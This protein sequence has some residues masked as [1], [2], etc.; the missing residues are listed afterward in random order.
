MSDKLEFALDE[1]EKTIDR[2]KVELGKTED[3]N[4]YWKLRE[5]YDIRTA[6]VER[7]RGALESAARKM[8]MAIDTIDHALNSERYRP[9]LTWHG[10]PLEKKKPNAVVNLDRKEQYRRQRC[11][12][13]GDCACAVADVPCKYEGEEKP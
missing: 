2:L 11:K 3:S 13:E 1:A 10:K 7:L 5:R 8:N 9:E 4:T 12:E 6:E